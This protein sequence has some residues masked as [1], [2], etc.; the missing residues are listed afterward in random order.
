[1]DMIIFFILLAVLVGAWWAR[2]LAIYRRQIG[3]K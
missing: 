3:G 1:M 2:V